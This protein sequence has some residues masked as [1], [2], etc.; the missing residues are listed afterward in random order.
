MMSIE[1]IAREIVFVVGAT[2][3]AN[4]RGRCPKKDEGVERQAT[5][6]AF[7][8]QF[9]EDNCTKSYYDVALIELSEDVDTPHVCLPH[10]H[11]MDQFDPKVDDLFSFGFGM[12]RSFLFPETT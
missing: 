5:R 6:V 1:E 10:L 2:C 12:D 8:K 4:E 11:E 7:N 9:F 3:R